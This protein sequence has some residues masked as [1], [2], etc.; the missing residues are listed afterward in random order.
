MPGPSLIEIDMQAVNTT[1]H[2]C[3]CECECDC[4]SE[5]EIKKGAGN[6]DEGLWKAC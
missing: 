4:E 2:I 1:P 3:E 5:S 6:A